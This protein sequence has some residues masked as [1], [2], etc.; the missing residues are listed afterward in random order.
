MPHRLNLPAD[1]NKFYTNSFEN[2]MTVL[3]YNSWIDV[4]QVAENSK[5]NAFKF[6]HHQIVLSAFEQN[7][8]L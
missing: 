8:I 2:P 1:S 3:L 7:E 5:N 6:L 4:F